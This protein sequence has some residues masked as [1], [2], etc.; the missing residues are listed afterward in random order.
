LEIQR[1]FLALIVED[2]PMNASMLQDLLKDHFPDIRVAGIAS[3]LHEARTLIKC[4]TID[5]LFLDI[6]LPDGNGFDLLSAM[7]EVQFEVIITPHSNYMLEHPHRHFAFAPV[8][9]EWAMPGRVIKKFESWKSLCRK[10][11]VQILNA[12][13]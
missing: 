4:L 13:N 2:N 3:S 12:E 8:T 10:K 9:A 1:E 7:P 6:E 11:P 5:L